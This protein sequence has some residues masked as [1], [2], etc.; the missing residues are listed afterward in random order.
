M[1]NSAL[2]TPLEPYNTYLSDPV[3]QRA[4]ER[5][6]ASETDRSSLA[7]FGAEVGSEETF[8]W[9]ADAN[10]YSPELVTHDRFG[11]RIDEVRYHPAYHQMMNLSVTN[12]IHSAHYGGSPG[13][14]SYVARTAQMHLVSQIEVGHACPISMTGAVL[15]ALRE[16]SDLASVWEPRIRT[17]SYDQRLIEPSLKTGNLLGMGLTESK[18]E[19]TFERIHRR[20]CQ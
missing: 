14:G 16:Q 15:P 7:S 9:G 18:A 1:E 3:L 2:V 10:R 13:D 12:G 5:E 6:G 17:R 11:D 20:R 8:S 19:V 4:V